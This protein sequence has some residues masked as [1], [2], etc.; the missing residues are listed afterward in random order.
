MSV[1]M[2]G[3]RRALVSGVIFIVYC[4]FQFLSR[5]EVPTGTARS[6]VVSI[7]DTIGCVLFLNPIGPSG[8]AQVE[9]T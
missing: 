6:V 4:A 5:F 9:L 2:C 1:G 7:T 8:D 3:K